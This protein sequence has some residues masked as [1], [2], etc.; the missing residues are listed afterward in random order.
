M[1]Q[2]NPNQLD[3][4]I[5]YGIVDQNVDDIIRCDRNHVNIIYSNSMNPKGME[6]LPI[7]L[8]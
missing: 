4:H 5:G 1:I 2:Q 3:N 8:P 6:K 7:P